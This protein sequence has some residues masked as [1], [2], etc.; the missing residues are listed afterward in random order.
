MNGRARF[1]LRVSLWAYSVLSSSVLYAAAPPL[2]P[3]NVSFEG[4]AVAG[5]DQVRS[6]AAFIDSIGVNT[7]F[8]HGNTA[9]YTKFPLV[10]QK[11][12]ESGITHIRDGAPDKLGKFPPQD[13]SAVFRELGTAGIRASFIFNLNVG[14]EFVQG[15]PA[16]VAP[17]F[18]AYE[19]PNEFNTKPDWVAALRAW[20]PVF[21]SYVRSNPASAIYPIIGPSLMDLGNN[22]H[23]QLGDLSEFMD[24]GNIHSYYTSRHPG[25]L[26]WGGPGNDGCE[27]WRYGSLAYKTCGQRRV[28]GTKPIMATETGW[29]TDTTQ[30]NQIPDYLQ[31]RYLARM[32]LLHFDAGI[33][34]TFIYQFVDA[35]ADG[36]TAYGLLTAQVEEK[37]AFR[38]I[39]ALIRLLKDPAG[40]IPPQ[41]SPASVTSSA[42]TIRV[43]LFQKRDR[44]F[45]MILWLEASGF[46]PVTLKRIAVPPQSA[47]LLLTTGARVQ[48]V[49]TFQDDG[50]PVT[51]PAQQDGAAEFTLAVSDNL[52]IVEITR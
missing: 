6:A 28:S 50:S 16:R 48:S 9:Y 17:S 12:L 34:R 2:P 52:T 10:K 27:Q 49:T 29:G 11:L 44:T 37:P 4:S 25:T 31:A 42:N 15:Y 40:V 20:A 23:T 24:Y 36:F 35:G 18:E 3:G 30:K 47:T 13:S 51:T 46:D 33:A 22:P 19:Y 1:S 21:K 45:A 41:T 5:G 39:K 38:E 43:M 32:L 26:G 7:H 8:N 14:T